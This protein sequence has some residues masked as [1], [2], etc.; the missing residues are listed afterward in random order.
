MAGALVFGVVNHF[1][2]ESADHVMQVNPDWRLLFGSTAAL[3]AL[4]EGGGTIVGALG[5]FGRNASR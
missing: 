2:L 4:L 5:A 1:V 3:L